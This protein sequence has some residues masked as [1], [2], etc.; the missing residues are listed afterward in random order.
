MRLLRKC[1]GLARV[2]AI[3]WPAAMA[4]AVTGPAVAAA[5]A[6]AVAAAVAGPAV[7]A[8]AAGPAEPSPAARPPAER[9]GGGRKVDA[10]LARGAVIKA[11]PLLFGPPNAM[12]SLDDSGGAVV[13]ISQDPGLSDGDL[14]A[15]AAQI[16]SLASGPPPEDPEVKAL[17]DFVRPDF[18]M[19]CKVRRVPAALA[20][21][22]SA[23]VARCVVE[24]A[25]L[26][27]YRLDGVRILTFRAWKRGDDIVQV[28]HCRADGTTKVPLKDMFFRF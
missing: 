28:A 20:G 2:L 27:D 7:A 14:E 3:R 23:H 24:R 10:G 12:D 4:A 13:V 9:A 19:G 26:P 16:G 25:Y 5:V 1:D 21:D 15:L 8:G 11:S 22:R 18:M 6:T 17:A